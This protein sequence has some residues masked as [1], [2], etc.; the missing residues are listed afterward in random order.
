MQQILDNEDRTLRIYF[1][2]I[3]GSR[4]LSRERE[5]ELAARIQYGD[6]RARDELVQ[7]NLRFVIDVAKHYH[8]RGLALSD[9][10]SAG[11]LGLL[12]AAERFDGAKGAKFISYTVW[13]IRHFI[14]Q[15]IGDQ[16]RTVRLP[17]N[18]INLLS[19]ISKASRRLGQGRGADPGVEEIASDLG[20]P[21][22]EVSE[23]LLSALNTVS[24][25]EDFHEDDERNLENIL[26]DHRQPS[27]EAEMQSESARAIVKDMLSSLD[28]R[29]ARILRL[30][31]GLDGS[32]PLT[33]EQIGAG[34]GVTRERVRQLKEKA[35][36]KFRHPARAPVLRA[37]MDELAPAG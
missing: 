10:I 26:L 4:P 27:P 9:L 20:L 2:D 29:E 5:V 16:G 15:T 33:L 21:V 13:W 31:Y 25:D 18:R 22:V 36:D 28:E 7:A 24:L 11:N 23:A 3:T 32:E 35:L 17:F 34:L 1:D 6:L 30:Y 14:L 12:T 37:L 19:Q 8:S